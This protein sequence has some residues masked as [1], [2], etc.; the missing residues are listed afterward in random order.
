MFLISKIE[1]NKLL[2]VDLS[3]ILYEIF[4]LIF[5][6][7][8]HI[9]IQSFNLL[10]LSLYPLNFSTEAAL[11]LTMLFGN[12]DDAFLH[13]ENLKG[14]LFCSFLSKAIIEQEHSL[15]N[16]LFSSCFKFKDDI[17]SFNS[18]PIFSKKDQILA[19]VI[20]PNI[21]DSYQAYCLLYT[22]TTI[23]ILQK[24]YLGVRKRNIC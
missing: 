8:H 5:C 9:C 16:F 7:I 11:S 20:T 12:K 23:T 13:E 21:I 18:V 2:F 22:K 24:I 1:F 6:S 10:K 4:I 17:I 19:L 14:L 15:K 3:F